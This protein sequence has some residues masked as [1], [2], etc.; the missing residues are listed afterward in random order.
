MKILH[1]LRPDENL[2]SVV[3]PFLNSRGTIES[4]IRSIDKAMAAIDR[5]KIEILFVDNGSTDG[6]REIVDSF[7]TGNDRAHCVTEPNIGVSHAR[8]KGLSAS[9]GEYIAFVDS[10]DEVGQYYFSAIFD[11]IETRPDLVVFP[12]PQLDDA[13]SF[14]P[15]PNRCAMMAELKG[16]WCWQFIFRFDLC[17]G[18]TFNGLCYEDFGFFPVILER[19]ERIIILHGN[20]YAYHSNAGSLTRQDSAW[21]LEQLELIADKLLVNGVLHDQYIFKRVKSDYLQA[22]M[23]LR[24][25]TCVWPVLPWQDFTHLFLLSHS[26]RVRLVAQVIRLSMSILRRKAI[27]LLR[28]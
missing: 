16:W 17:E 10:D 13:T 18:L 4:T 23:Q 2:L 14:N 7:C 3:I 27:Q 28:I 24:A 5:K 1:K 26:G 15:A 6:S 12:F 20:I 9:R 22:K 8:N 11:S 25:I 19:C 21:R